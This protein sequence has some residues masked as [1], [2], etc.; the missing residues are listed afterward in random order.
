MQRW[1]G[2]SSCEIC[3]WY[4]RGLRS[5]C[6][7]GLVEA[8]G[9]REAESEGIDGVRNKSGRGAG[10]EAQRCV[11]EVESGEQKARPQD[12]RPGLLKLK[13]GLQR[14]AETPF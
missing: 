9:A 3:P 12:S 2:M 4:R 14:C 10:R 1:A 13:L 7:A 8:L 6:D 5:V 11:K